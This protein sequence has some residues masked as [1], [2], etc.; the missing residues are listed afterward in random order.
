MKKNKYKKIK[1][2]FLP[3]LYIYCSSKES[4]EKLHKDMD[5]PLEEGITETKRAFVSWLENSEGHAIIYLYLPPSE[6]AADD[7]FVMVHE[8]CHVMDFTN[9]RLGIQGCTESRAYLFEYMFK[10]FYEAYAKARAN[11]EL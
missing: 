8:M 10:K 11:M 2:D 7:L 4:L 3:D 5:S 6:D 1:Q 9:E